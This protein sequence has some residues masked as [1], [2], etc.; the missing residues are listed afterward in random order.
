M[1]FVKD[2]K[3]L[4][5]ELFNNAGEKLLGHRTKD[6][7]GKN[8]YDFFPKKQAEFFISKDKKVLKS[9]TLLDIKEEPIQTKNGLR[10]LHTKKI[11]LLDKKGKS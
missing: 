8:D 2:A 1:I 5:F 9:K 6:L 7:I 3:D 4:K 11:P 10:F